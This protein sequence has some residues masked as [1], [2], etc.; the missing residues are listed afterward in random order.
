MDYREALEFLRK[1]AEKHGFSE[2]E[3]GHNFKEYALY[4]VFSSNKKKL[5][6]KR[7]ELKNLIKLGTEGM[8]KK[9]IAGGIRHERGHFLRPSV[10]EL[11]PK[12][13][14]QGNPILKDYE[15]FSSLLEMQA[16]V[17]SASK[18]YESNAEYIEYTANQMS[19]DLFLHDKKARKFFKTSMPEAEKRRKMIEIINAALDEYGG[20]SCFNM[21]FKEEVIFKALEI[22]EPY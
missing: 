5:Y 2:I 8:I 21:H 7:K 3:T 1:E 13:K 22:L 18:L 11:L 20:F 10:K 17:A 4:Y 14:E 15:K 19:W 12:L 9:M 16:N 6:Y